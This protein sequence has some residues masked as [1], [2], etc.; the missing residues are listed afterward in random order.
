MYRNFLHDGE[1]E[2]KYKWSESADR[3]AAIGGDYAG[4]TAT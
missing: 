1:A 2:G 4:I 3:I